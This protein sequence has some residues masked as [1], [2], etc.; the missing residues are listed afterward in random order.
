[1]PDPANQAVPPSDTKRYVD[2]SIIWPYI[3]P[4]LSV[5][6]TAILPITLVGLWNMNHTVSQLQ[7][8]L[9]DHARQLEAFGTVGADI[10]S[11]RSNIAKVETELRGHSDQLQKFYEEKIDASNINNLLNA[12]RGDI[13]EL[14]SALKTVQLQVQSHITLVSNHERELL[15]LRNQTDSICSG[16]AS[17]KERIAVVETKLPAVGKPSE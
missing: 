5:A 4:L 15:T 13:D 7:T 11:I 1:M 12:D 17:I 10:S 14:E 16:L 9:D 3:W 6:V 2:L 8:K